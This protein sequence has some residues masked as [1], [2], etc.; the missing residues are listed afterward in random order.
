MFVLFVV[1]PYHSYSQSLSSPAI[2]RTYRNRGCEL[3][4][5]EQEGQKHITIAVE[6]FI[7]YHTFKGFFRL[8]AKSSIAA[9][10]SAPLLL[11]TKRN[12]LN[13]NTMVRELPYETI[14]DVVETWELAKQHPGFEDITALAILEK[15]DM[16]NLAETTDVS[17]RIFKEPL[18]NHEQSYSHH[19]LVMFF[20]PFHSHSD[21]LKLN[22]AHALYLD[23][24]PRPKKMP[25]I[26]A[27]Q[28]YTAWAFSF[29]R[30]GW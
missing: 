24:P 8:A 10:P 27:N 1:S 20:F 13:N 3:R 6:W 28:R 18:V 21:F 30:N 19:S 14:G 5:P 4:T 11:P 16:L 15:Y 7:Q 25:A 9:V 29:T 2:Q 17:A 22:P 26:Y 23:Y 12:Y